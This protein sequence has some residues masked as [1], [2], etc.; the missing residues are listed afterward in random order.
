MNVTAHGVAALIA[1]TSGGV[2]PPADLMDDEGVEDSDAGSGLDDPS[3][4]DPL[5]GMPLPAVLSA[6]EPQLQA[7]LARI[8]RQ[9]EK[10][11]ADLYQST[12]GRVY[13]LAMRIVRDAPTAEEVAEDTF[14]QVWRQAPRFDPTRGCALAWL[15]TITRSRALDAVRAR[16]RSQAHTVSFD[17][18]EALVDAETDVHDRTADDPR[19]LLSAV[20]SGHLLQSA[21][22][23]LGPVPRQ[24]VSLA[25]FGGMTHEEI[26]GQTGM[27][28]GTVKS[29]IRRALTTLR[30]WL[31]PQAQSSPLASSAMGERR[32]V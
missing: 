15:L 4:D 28:L 10:A 22:M 31:A 26:A 21:L 32:S 19:E 11:L 7:W 2:W 12:I 29:H 16:Q 24:L 5:A 23:R 25:F 6:D 17:A 18:I 20:Q 14:W 3:E 1:D 27:P 13:G 30:T 8:V 9:D